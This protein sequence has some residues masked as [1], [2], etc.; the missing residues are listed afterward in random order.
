MAPGKASLRRSG[1]MLA[2][3]LGAIL[4]LASG[5]LAIAGPA[6]PQRSGHA[7]EPSGTLTHGSPPPLGVRPQLAPA[8][9]YQVERNIPLP[10]D[11]TGVVF[12][13]STDQIF[14]AVSSGFVEV[15]SDTSDAV[16]AS[17]DVGGSPSGLAYDR[18]DHDVYVVDTG[19]YSANVSAISDGSDTVVANVYV[20]AN[21]PGGIVVDP[22]LGEILTT[23]GAGCL[24]GPCL[25]VIDDATNTVSGDIGLSGDLGSWLG[26]DP[27]LHAIVAPVIGCGGDC[28]NATLISASSGKVL[29]RV[30]VGPYPSGAAYDPTLGE[31]YFV[32]A[33]NAR[34][35]GSGC[36]YFPPGNVT[37]FSDLTETVLANTSIDNDLAGAA[38]DPVLG[39]VFVGSYGVSAPGDVYVLSAASD[40]LLATVPVGAQ[41][42]A[43]AYDSNTGQLFT[44]NANSA[45]L[46]VIRGEA[47]SFSLAFTESGIPAKTLSKH[48]WTVVLNGT[49]DHSVSNTNTFPGLPNGTYPVLITGPTGFDLT[50]S[51]TVTVHG[52]TTVD[53]VA[54][55]GKTVTLTFHEKKLAKA[56]NWCVTVD[57]DQECSTKATVKFVDLA[58]G[59]YSYAIGSVAGYAATAK[60]GKAPEPLTGT[61]S[62]TKSATVTVTFAKSE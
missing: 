33:F 26:Y 22:T 36:E 27:Q 51:G 5:G 50:G 11:P 38:F 12:D 30:P 10:A 2:I 57:G 17:V 45:N 58:P 41:P 14:V 25:T 40:A 39:A 16:V 13:A 20:G 59:T 31:E 24:S 60:M 61:L 46:S 54:T 42:D 19:L 4:L 55:K 44:A 15:I 53:V 6:G 48:G 23:G 7:A 1:P 49:V 52:D 43:I 34:C 28:G 8:G 3:A 37:A 9:V 29:D 56:T 62:L 21:V 35:G 47:P 32:N 18:A